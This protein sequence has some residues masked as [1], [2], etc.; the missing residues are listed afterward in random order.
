M[1]SEE[2]VVEDEDDEDEDDDDDDK[3]DDDVEGKY[4][5][6]LS[7][8]FGSLSQPVLKI[9]V[10]VLFLNLQHFDSNVPV[11]LDLVIWSLPC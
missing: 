8:S 3:D 1:Q 2:P 10:S 6:H 9:D 7:F 4:A 11:K 5:L